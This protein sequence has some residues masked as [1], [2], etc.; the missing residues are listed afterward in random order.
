MEFHV[1][2]YMTELD[3]QAKIIC[4]WSYVRARSSYNLSSFYRINQLCLFSVFQEWVIIT[5][6]Q[7]TNRQLDGSLRDES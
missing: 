3:E 1:C 4:R 7:S 6:F 2:Q 5:D